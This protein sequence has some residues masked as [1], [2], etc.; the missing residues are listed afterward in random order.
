[1]LEKAKETADIEPG[2]AEGF[3]QPYKVTYDI[4]GSNKEKPLYTKTRTVRASSEQEA[5]DTLRK[6]VGGTNYR[7]EKQGVEEGWKS[8]AAA[9]ALAG[10]MASPQAHSISVPAFNMAPAVYQTQ[11]KPKQDQEASRKAGRA[12]P[13]SQQSKELL[14]K[15]DVDSD[16]SIKDL[17]ARFLPLA[18]EYLGL[19]KLPKINI[20]MSLPDHNGQASFG[21]YNS[22]TKEIN[23]AITNRHPVD[24]FRTLAHELVHYKQDLLGKIK[25]YS[26]DTGSTEE[27]QANTVAGIIMRLFNKAHPDAINAKVIS[28]DAQGIEEDIVDDTVQYHDTLEPTVWQDGVL[29]PEIRNRLLTI[30]KQFI[31]SLNVDNIKCKF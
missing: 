24:I 29:K 26:G 3:E 4:Y 22:S 28:S 30:A 18:A 15:E 17:F 23:L 20:E 1:M 6:L 25:D 9:A 10:T 5:I 8:K 13:L 2:V 27:N 21:G 7:V 31:D 19:D 12:F 14:K 16:S 11:I